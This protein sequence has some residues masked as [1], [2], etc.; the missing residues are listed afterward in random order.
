MPLSSLAL[1]AALSLAAPSRAAGAPDLAHARV[2][3][4]VNFPLGQQP[5]PLAFSPGGRELLSIDSSGLSLWDV[6]GKRL[7]WRFGLPAGRE[8]QARP[9]WAEWHG[10][11]IVLYAEGSVNLFITR[12]DAQTG[13]VLGQEKRVA[14]DLPRR[15]IAPEVPAARLET[16]SHTLW[17][18]DV[19]EPPFDRRLLATYTY[20]PEHG[21]LAFKGPDEGSENG[22][23]VGDQPVQVYSEAAGK[24]IFRFQTVLPDWLS[25]SSTLD[26]LD[27]LSF[28]PDGR[29][30]GW[31]AAGRLTV[32]DMESGTKVAVLRPQPFEAGF[33]GPR[34]TWGSD[35]RTVTLSDST[36][37]RLYRL[38]DGQLLRSRDVKEGFFAF[39]P[40]WDLAGAE[41]NALNIQA[42]GGESF[43]LGRSAGSVFFS[44]TDRSFISFTDEQTAW[45]YPGGAREVVQLHLSR[46]MQ[47]ENVRLNLAAGTLD[48]FGAVLTPPDLQGQQNTPPPVFSAQRISLTAALKAGPSAQPFNVSLTEQRRTTEPNSECVQGQPAER[49]QSPQK[50]RSWPSPAYTLRLCES[51]Y[52]LTARK[53]G[54]GADGSALWRVARPAGS[55]PT[56]VSHDDHT[57]LLTFPERE[58]RI[59]HAANASLLARLKVPGQGK[60]FPSAFCLGPD[61]RV[62]AL[63]VEDQWHFYDLRTKLELP[64]PPALRRARKL[65]FVDGGK[66]LAVQQDSAVVFYDLQQR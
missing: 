46:P 42:A 15:I 64:A 40:Q 57:L 26:R 38:P 11:E 66:A 43:R 20:A 18:T 35:S 59:Y 41:P 45:L 48:L 10:G 9:D 2:S 34:V 39:S 25:S 23:E 33:R 8:W 60:L 17:R 16:L 49:S 44:E 50:G 36:W 53:L 32:W 63:Q 4:Q 6:T 62:L 5:W 27:Q 21:L 30:L 24:V 12:L 54:N 65:D 51:P 58:V 61:E 55:G 47:V 3:A 22:I 19:D 52:L 31:S 28:S 37:L 13:K 29:Y 14:P 7:L 56:L 1:L